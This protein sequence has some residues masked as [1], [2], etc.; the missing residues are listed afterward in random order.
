MFKPKFFRFYGIIIIYLFFYI[1]PASIFSVSNSIDDDTR[2]ANAA[3]CLLAA[4]P[5]DDSVEEIEERESQKPTS[6]KVSGK[7]DKSLPDD[8][9]PDYL[10]STRYARSKSGNVTTWYLMYT[11]S[12]DIFDTVNELFEEEVSS[13]EVKLSANNITNSIIIKAKEKDSPI[14]N[15]IIDTIKSLDF[16]SGQVLIEVL[17]V[18][19]GVTDEDLF[20]FELMNIVKEPF[21]IKNTISNI[22]VDHGNIEETNPFSSTDRLKVFVTTPNRMKLFLNAYK[23]LGKA[24]IISSPHIV[25]ANHREASFKIGNKVPIIDSIRPSDQGPIKTFDIKEVGIELTVTPHINRA[26]Q[27]DLEV[28][29]AINELQFYDPSQG[30]ANMTHREVTTNVT[31]GDG[32]TLILGGF[33]EDKKIRTENRIPGLSR[34]PLVGKLFRRRENSKSKVELLIFITPKIIDT[35]EDGKLALENQIEKV[36]FKNRVKDLLDKLRIKRQKLPPNQKYIIKRGSRDWKYDYDRKDIEELVWDIPETIDPSQLNLRRVGNMPF[37]FG[38]SNRRN[39]PQLNTEL[40]PSEGFI[41]AKEF[42]VNEPEKVKNM[43][44]HVASDDAAVVYINGMIVDQD[45]LIKLKDGHDFDYWNRTVDN[46]PGSILRKGI[47][48]IVVFLGCD[49]TTRDAYLDLELIEVN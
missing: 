9:D 35:M 5:A 4:V 38:T 23:D 11:R 24:K 33:I 25:S 40:V 18:E 10:I 2:N 31:L 43:I 26:D 1:F 14:V 27:I 3:G 22:G 41:M 20:D 39:A 28:F 8:Y 44:L 49:K 37:G 15:E 30:T 6:V 42:T 29:Q 17:V 19:L 12:Q 48:S 47:N 7:L 36:S 32:E 45:P 16:R 34:L 21:N 46:I 13:G